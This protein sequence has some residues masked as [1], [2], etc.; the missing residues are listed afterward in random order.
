M[1]Q[2]L[3]EYITSLGRWVWVVLVDFILAGVGA[4]LDISN[5]APIPTWVWLTLLLIGLIVAPFVAFHKLRLQRDELK[6]QLDD[7]SRRQS[8]KDALSEFMNE[9]LQLRR[10][11]ADENKPPPNDEAN[12]WATRVE[13]YL[14]NHRGE[15]YVSRFRSDAGLPMTATSIS[16]MPHRNLW[17]GI[18]TRLSRLEQFIAEIPD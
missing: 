6:S 15:S 13:A 10:Q 5:A 2:S 17:G 7:K 9:G 18:H 12:D 8:I 11:C 4:Y 14:A 3:K 16:S 1:R